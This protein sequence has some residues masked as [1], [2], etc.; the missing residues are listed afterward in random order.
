MPQEGFIFP[1]R[2][3]KL[4]RNEAKYPVENARGRLEKYDELGAPGDG[5]E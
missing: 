1:I 4:A 2:E 3:A 5:W